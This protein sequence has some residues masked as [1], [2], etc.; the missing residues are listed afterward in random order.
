MAHHLC[1]AFV[2]WKL[3]FVSISLR[4]G[5]GLK[6]NKFANAF[7]R[8]LCNVWFYVLTKVSN[9]IWVTLAFGSRSKLCNFE[10]LKRVFD[11]DQRAPIDAK[12]GVSALDAI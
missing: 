10:G 12:K 11:E 9:A 1:V 4:K 2:R 5:S 3:S 8:F 7:V 6:L